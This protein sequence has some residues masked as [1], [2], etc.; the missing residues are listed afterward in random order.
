[1]ICLECL[2]FWHYC[3]NFSL[4]SVPVILLNHDSTFT[5]LG[6]F[7]RGNLYGWQWRFVLIFTELRDK[8]ARGMDIHGMKRISDG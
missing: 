3:E 5:D 8:V 1:M 7:S 2:H 4:F 6:V